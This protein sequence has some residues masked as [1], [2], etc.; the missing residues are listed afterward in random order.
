MSSVFENNL[1][2]TA[3][4]STE[5]AGILNLGKQCHKCNAVDFLPYHC[6]FCDHTYC[7]NHRVLESHGCVR[8]SSPPQTSNYTGPSAASLFPDRLKHQKMLEE[9]IKS[10][11]TTIADKMKQ[12]AAPSALMKLTK[13]LHLERVKR[14]KKTLFGK[15]KASKTPNRV[16]E[17]AKIKKVAKGA[18]VPVQDRVYVWAL[19]VNRNEEDLGQIDAEKER[20]GVWVSKNWS[21]GRALDSLA[22]VLGIMNQNNLTQ[23]TSERLNLFKEENDQIVTL[24]NSKKVS[25]SL[26]NG[27]MVYLVR[28]T[29]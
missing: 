5:D 1:F 8:P 18:T 14:Q 3:V 10:K 13:F 17:L 28:G 27:D 26:A 11:P 2:M 23:Q 7:S 9:Q 15:T 22:D 20:K 19:F 4:R 21:V 25:V 6:E 29:I 24:E 16:V 12:S